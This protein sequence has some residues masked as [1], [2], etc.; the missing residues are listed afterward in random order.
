MKWR[1]PARPF[2]RWQCAGQGSESRQLHSL[3]S[4]RS[5][6]APIN[7]EC[8]TRLSV[9]PREPHAEAE[10]TTGPAVDRS[11]LTRVTPA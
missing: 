4:F 1:R 11:H 6:P 9:T 7:D 3:S 8:P 5:A 10:M 2:L